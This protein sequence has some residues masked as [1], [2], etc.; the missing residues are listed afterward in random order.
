[1][2]TW[3]WA[4]INCTSSATGD[5]K[6]QPGYV[7]FLSSSDGVMTGSK[8]F[9]VHMTNSAGGL[10]SDPK[11]FFTG[12]MIVHGAISASAYFIKDIHEIQVSGSTYFGDSNEDVHI[13][14]GSLI[15]T[16]S[17]APEDALAGE[18]SANQYIL[19]SSFNPKRVHVRGI[20]GRYRVVTDAFALI[21]RDDYIIGVSG[22]L[23]QTL[24]LPTASIEMKGALM[25]IKDEVA[26]RTGL[27][28][29]VHLSCA[30][31]THNEID[32]EASYMLTGTMPAINLYCNGTGQWFVF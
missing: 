18:T 10:L 14:T 2:A 15:V 30:A 23:N 26:T 27:P 28:N 5:G 7:Q 6:G 12:T 21:H 19:S 8:N 25:V 1:M 24:W 20:A 4:Y 22:N 17:Q 32:G 13:R 11:L 16:A 31:G 9:M 3:G 29:A